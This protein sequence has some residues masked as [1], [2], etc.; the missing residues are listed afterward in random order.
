MGVGA[1]AGQAGNC[2]CL[3]A[4]PRGCRGDAREKEGGLVE[5]ELCASAQNRASLG[6][7]GGGSFVSKRPPRSSHK[8]GK[9]S[10]HSRRAGGGQKDKSGERSSRVLPLKKPP[11][12]VTAG[13]E[14]GGG[15]GSPSFPR[16]PPAGFAG[17]QFLLL[18]FASLP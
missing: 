5:P 18:F 4:P 2:P 17:G 13:A 1:A 6:E 12:P 8:G 9:C 15:A 3:T 11:E 16:L 10:R 14:G 7:Q